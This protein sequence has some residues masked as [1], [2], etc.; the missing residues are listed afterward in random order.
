MHTHSS[1]P[2]AEVGRGEQG[3]CPGPHALMYVVQKFHLFHHLQCLRD[4]NIIGEGELIMKQKQS[5]L[6]FADLS[7][8]TLFVTE[9]NVLYMQSN[10]I[11]KVF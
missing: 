6:K 2:R 1:I 8:G 7:T 5:R 11:H 10:K 3:G 9:H 4:K